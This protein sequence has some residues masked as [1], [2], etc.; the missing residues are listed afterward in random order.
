[1]YNFRGSKDSDR[2]ISQASGRYESDNHSSRDF[3]MERERD[4]ERE[5]G[6][7]ARRNQVN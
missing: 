7:R 4:K 3:I 2:R 5:L 6:E 1:M